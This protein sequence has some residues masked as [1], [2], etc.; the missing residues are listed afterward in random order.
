MRVAFSAMLAGLG[1]LL[2]GWV[3][4]MLISSL[5]HWLQIVLL[6]AGLALLIGG[7]LLGI[8]KS[9]SNGGD[10]FRQDHSGT[11]DNIMKVRR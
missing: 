3:L 4:P 5:P 10:T 2:A 11:G 9:R 1:S 6:I 8:S 7:A